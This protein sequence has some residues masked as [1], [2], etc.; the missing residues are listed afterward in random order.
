MTHPAEPSLAPDPVRDRVLDLLRA[1]RARL[2]EDYGVRDLA[3]FGSVARG[4]ATEDSDVDLVVEFDPERVTLTSFLDFAEDVEALLGR[5]VDLV[6]LPKL[7]PDSAHGSRRRRC[8]SRDPRVDLERIVVCAERVLDHTLGLEFD[9]F[10]ADALRY[11][12]TL[13]NLEIMGEAAKRVPEEVRAR[14]PA[15][16]WRDLAG[17]RDRLAHGYD[18]LDDRVIRD[19][20]T[21]G[22]P[23]TRAAVG[24]A[25]ASPG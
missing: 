1:H 22:V 23:R 20:V 25:L 4:E 14:F 17:F 16:P 6:S 13:R 21:R 3:L 2:A 5:R 11:D 12:A 7:P 15:V 24:G 19:A 9:G 10:V 8:V 18:A